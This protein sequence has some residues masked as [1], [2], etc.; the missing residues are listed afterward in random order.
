MTFRIGIETATL[1]QRSE[2]LRLVREAFS[3][4]GRDGHDQVYIVERTWAVRRGDDGPGLDLGL[5]LVAIVEGVVIGHVMAAYGRLNERDDLLAVAPLAVAP[6]HQGKGVGRALMTDLLRR[7]D[8]AGVRVVALL[9][10]PRLYGR[11]GFEPASRY[12]VTYP[13]VRASSPDFQVR[14]APGSSAPKEGAFR[15]CWE[16]PLQ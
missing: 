1:G 12:T 13:P 5:E 8:E 10:S 2:I 3:T 14:R 15:Y 4:G 11:F 7:T 6:S 9:G 16:D